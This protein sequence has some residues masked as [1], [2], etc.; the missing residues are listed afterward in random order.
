MR[1]PAEI[2]RFAWLSLLCIVFVLMLFGPPVAAQGEAEVHV[3]RIDGEIDGQAADYV[4]RVISEAGEA[5][6][7]AVVIS[8]DTPGGRLDS[9]QEMVEKI[10]NADEVPIIAYVSPQGAQAASA[11]TFVLMASDVAAMAPQTRTGAATPV[12]AWGT[13]IPGDLGEK[14][15]NDATAFITGL[16]DAHGRNEEWAEKAVR[17]GAAIDAGEARDIGVVEHVEPDLRSVLEAADGERVEPKGITLRTANASLIQ[18]EPTFEDRFGFSAYYVAVP[19][20]LLVLAVAGA[21]LAARRTN[22]WRVSTG[23]EGMIGEVGT[24]RRRVSGSSGGM[25][26]VHGELWKAL[27]EDAQAA[28]LEPGTEVEVVGFRRTAI[29]V[30]EAKEF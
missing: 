8:L 28:P 3:A 7:R 1:D 2:R 15:R 14:V 13:D 16:A 5:N 17:K 27:A 18:Q 6:A 21:A 9:T 11:G 19:L 25:V 12:T 10:S 26:F 29:V 30:R 22:R 23:R 4:G 20:V 24:V